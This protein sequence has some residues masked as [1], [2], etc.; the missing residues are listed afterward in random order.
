MK[1]NTH[2]LSAILFKLKHFMV[3]Y[4]QRE[5]KLNWKIIL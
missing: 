4:L 1:A 2:G 5:K 3:I